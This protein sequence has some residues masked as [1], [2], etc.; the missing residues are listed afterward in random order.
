[1]NVQPQTVVE[2]QEH[3]SRYNLE[4]QRA[5]GQNF[6]IDGNLMRMIVEAAELDP[7][8]DTVL[9]VGSGTGSL[10]SMLAEAAR[11]VVTVEADKKLT[12]LL[13]EVL[14]GRKNVKLLI[15][16]ALAGKHELAPE[17][18][19]ALRKHLAYP[20]D[21]RLKLV[22]NLPYVI[23]TPLVMNLILGQ[24]RPNLLVFTVQKE[25]A[26]RLAARCGDSAYCPA[27]IIAQAVAS[28]ELLHI[29]SP[30][31]F[32]PKPQIHSTLMRIRPEAARYEQVGDL[33]LFQRVVHGLFAHRRK[34]C[35]KSLEHAT[36]LDEFRGRWAE[37]LSAAGIPHDVRGDTL[38][39]ERILSLVKA[40]A[41]K[42]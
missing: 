27:G 5:L 7:L 42:L 26:D 11:E 40:A 23:A 24:P 38:E 31:V 17:V 33:D 30:N 20:P 37:L 8:R 18:V 29:F 3:L 35:V 16:D 25:V 12:P 22:S 13:K 2:I 39:L 6:L 4:P 14:A 41:N 1:M 28:V 32:W 15:L 10:T 19:E 9:E 36:G 34:T 21:A